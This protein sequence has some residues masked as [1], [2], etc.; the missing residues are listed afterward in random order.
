MSL[1]LFAAI[2][3]PEDIANRLIDLQG[4]VHGASWRSLEQLHLTLR[5]FGEIDEALARDLDHELGLI[6]EAPFEI[7]LAAAGSFGGREP[8]AL[9][10][11]VEPSASLKRLASACEKAARRAGLGPEARKFTPHVTLA[12]CRGTSDE[13]TAQFQQE[14]G[15]FRT[16]LFWVDHFCMYSSH[17]T[18][19]GSQYVEEAVYPLTGSLLRASDQKA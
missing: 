3:L 8:S 10:A 18:R 9:W 13:D 7:R 12:Y 14:I 5:F 16:D 1:R 17:Q 19:N 15:A 4:E 11:G 2:P 6:A